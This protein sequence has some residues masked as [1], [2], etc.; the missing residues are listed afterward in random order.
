MKVFRPCHGIALIELA[1]VL[2]ILTLLFLGIVDYS[3]AIQ[4]ENIIIS[5][6]REG[7]NLAARTSYSPQFIMQA[8]AQTSSPLL[9]TSQG[10]II[11]TEFSAVANNSSTAKIE[12]Q[13]RWTGGK[14]VTSRLWKNCGNWSAGE[15]TIPSPAPTTTLPLTL[16]HQGDVVFAVEVF[17]EYNPIFDFVMTDSA[18]LYS[19]TLL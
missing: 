15:C 18:N 7:G 6:S 3:R 16:Q 8:L 11:I 13:S 10:G 1:L 17:Y 4:A 9:M 2:P 19:L 12:A 14:A 5:M